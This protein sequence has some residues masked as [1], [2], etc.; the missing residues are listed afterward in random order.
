MFDVADC[1][2][3]LKILKFKMMDQYAKIGFIRMKI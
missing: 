3:S 1:E 2:S